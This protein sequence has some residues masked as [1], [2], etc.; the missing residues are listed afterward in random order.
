V[1]VT[2]E[3][4]AALRDAVTRPLSELRAAPPSEAVEEALRDLHLLFA[5]HT[6]TRLRALRFARL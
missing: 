4:I 1:P 3:A 5:Y 2:P 6:G